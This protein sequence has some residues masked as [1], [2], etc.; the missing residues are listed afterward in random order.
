MILKNFWRWQRLFKRTV[1]RFNQRANQL[2]YLKSEGEMYPIIKHTQ[3]TSIF[4]PER[5]G[6]F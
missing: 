3:K 6:F 5:K 4:Y 2:G 1:A